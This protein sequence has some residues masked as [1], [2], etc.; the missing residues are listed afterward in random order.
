MRNKRKRIFI[1]CRM[2]DMTQSQNIS[3]LS[4]SMELTVDKGNN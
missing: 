3:L 2:E 4:E 1:G